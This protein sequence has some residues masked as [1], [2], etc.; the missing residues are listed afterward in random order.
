MRPIPVHMLLHQCWMER[1]HQ[2]CQLC[3]EINFGHHDFTN[4]NHGNSSDNNNHNSNHQNN[5]GLL[6]TES[7]ECL[8]NESTK[9]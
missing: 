3:G 7:N 6:Q 8:Q 9:P 5:Q 2:C 1:L 4:N